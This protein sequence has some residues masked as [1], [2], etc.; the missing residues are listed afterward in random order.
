[1]KAAVPEVTDFPDEPLIEHPGWNH[2]RFALPNGRVFSAEED[3]GSLA[4]FDID[5]ERCLTK[6]CSQD[7]YDA[8]KL[9]PD[10]HIANFC[11]SLPYAAPL[12][13]L[14]GRTENFGFE[15]MGGK[16]KGKSTLQQLAASAAGPPSGPDSEIV[17][18]HATVVGIEQVMPSYADML[19]NLEEANL[20]AGGSVGSR[21]ASELAHL[22]FMLSSGRLKRK[23]GQGV[24][25]QFR[26]IYL[27]STNEALYGLVSTAGLGAGAEASHDRLLTIPIA[28]DRPFGVFDRLPEG[29]ESSADLAHHLIAVVTRNHGWGLPSYL[30][31]LVKQRD[32]RKRGLKDDIRRRVRQFVEEVGVN[33]N[34]GSGMRVA[35]AFGL[36]YAAGLIAQK[37]G[38]I[39]KTWNPLEAAINCYFLNREYVRALPKP[40]D[41]IRQLGGAEGVIPFREPLDINDETFEQATGFMRRRKGKWE[42]LVTRKSF[43]RI[44][45][46][47]AP[48]LLADPDVR[49]MMKIE[50][51]HTAIK[52]KIRNSRDWDRVLCFSDKPWIWRRA[53]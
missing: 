14:I 26:F 46:R 17:P 18:L 34:D 53:V 49:D 32:T 24:R 22:T 8:M 9:L 12:L 39:P 10:Q 5:A 37:A 44:F 45:G 41:L 30:E 11:L 51:N 28:D 43:E 23:F 52:R 13:T 36:V 50:K 4:I 35:E 40:I 48:Y 31:F 1:M 38:V 20:F 42:L 2:G 25:N 7:W 29:F 21:R 19:L 33:K 6:G 47:R 3:D 15:L 16:G 27:M